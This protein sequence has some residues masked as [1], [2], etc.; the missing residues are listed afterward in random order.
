MDA[1]AEGWVVLE[2]E[3][4]R[5]EQEIALFNTLVDFAFYCGTA[6]RW[7][8]G[9]DKENGWRVPGS[10]F[11]VHPEGGRLVTRS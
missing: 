4:G 5:T 9:A 6:T 1:G 2:M 3:K 8:A 10:G 11:H 7:G